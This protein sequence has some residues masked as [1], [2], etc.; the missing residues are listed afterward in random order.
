MTSR[1]NGC[2][3]P[4]H[5][6]IHSLLSGNSHTLRLLP[7]VGPNSVILVAHEGLLWW[8]HWDG[9]TIA[10]LSFILISILQQLQ[11]VANLTLVE[12]I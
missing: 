12:A 4:S 9:A 10:N 6:V 5:G 8:N 7:E 2:L 11:S 3:R 1:L